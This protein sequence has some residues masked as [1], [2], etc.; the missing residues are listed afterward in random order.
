MKDPA[1][2][3]TFCSGAE[4]CRAG[5]TEEMRR[6]KAALLDPRRNRSACGRRRLRRVFAQR[7]SFHSFRKALQTCFGHEGEKIMTFHC[8]VPLLAHRPSSERV[9]LV[10]FLFLCFFCFLDVRAFLS[11]NPWPVGRARPGRRLVV[12]IPRDSHIGRVNLLRFNPGPSIL[13]P[14]SSAPWSHHL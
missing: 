8:V 9:L 11:M 4:K 14:A 10:Y 5:E 1:C 13:R 7:N 3:R 2:Y 12:L 6:L